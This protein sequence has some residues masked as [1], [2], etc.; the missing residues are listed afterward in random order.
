[1][2]AHLGAGQAVE[3]AR[4]AFELAGLHQAGQGDGWQAV[5]RHVTRAQKGALAREAQHLLFVGGGGRGFGSLHGY[6]VFRNDCE[7]Q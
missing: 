7:R 6:I 4:H 1:M 3:A 2:L 5:L